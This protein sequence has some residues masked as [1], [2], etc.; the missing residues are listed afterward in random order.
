[1]KIEIKQTVDTVPW[2]TGESEAP[3]AVTEVARKLSEAG[4]PTA[5]GKLQTPGG[6]DAWC[7]ICYNETGPSIA[8]LQTCE[9]PQQS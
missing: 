7:V 2:K 5:F 6:K 4:Y 8:S 3:Q 9:P 1:M